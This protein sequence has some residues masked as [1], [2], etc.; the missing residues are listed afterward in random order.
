MLIRIIDIFSLKMWVVDLQHVTS[1]ATA[2]GASIG[3]SIDMGHHVE[4]SQ[5]LKGSSSA[6]QTEDLVSNF[7]GSMA[8]HHKTFYAGQS[9]G[10]STQ[11]IISRFNYLGRD[12]AVDYIQ[13]N[14]SQG[15]DL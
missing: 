4:N 7:I 5:W 13:N 3:L 10:H 12:Q 11:Y 6:W 15:L 2:P 1:A 8:A 14:G 9:L